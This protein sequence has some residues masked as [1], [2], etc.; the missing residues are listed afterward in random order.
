M[1]VTARSVTERTK[2]EEFRQ[3]HWRRIPGCASR[4][5]AIGSGSI[6]APIGR[7]TGVRRS[8]ALLSQPPKTAVT[9]RAMAGETDG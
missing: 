5:N 7:H 1:I 9:V 6:R 8:V 4:W 3:G 2:K